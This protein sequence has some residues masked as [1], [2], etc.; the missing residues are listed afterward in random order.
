LTMLCA[1]LDAARARQYRD[2]LQDLHRSAG[3]FSI[4]LLVR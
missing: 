3:G 4:P 1:T 2:Q